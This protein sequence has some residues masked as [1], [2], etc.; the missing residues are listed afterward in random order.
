MWGCGPH[1]FALPKALRDRIWQ[2]YRAGQETD[3]RPSPAYL[4]A[5]R[6]VQEWI[7]STGRALP[8]QQR[9]L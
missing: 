2:T 1:W 7:T 9:L 5:A 8:V 4:E 3:K 6:A